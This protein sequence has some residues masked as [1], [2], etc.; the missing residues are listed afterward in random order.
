MGKVVI[1]ESKSIGEFLSQLNDMGEDITDLEGLYG[2]S[3]GQ[4]EPR[5]PIF[6][7][8]EYEFQKTDRL[9]N[10]KL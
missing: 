3:L 5:M 4:T 6:E 10:L 2:Y 9:T 7:Y 1:I 8:P